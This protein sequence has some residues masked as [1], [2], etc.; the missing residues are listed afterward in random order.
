MRA[1]TGCGAV[2]AERA[3]AGTPGC[4]SDGGATAGK[5]RAA[6][7]VTAAPGTVGMGRLEFN[8]AFA[9]GLEMVTL[10]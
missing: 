10:A 6:G 2:R 3:G 7:G 5:G 1:K 8:G 9:A 4:E